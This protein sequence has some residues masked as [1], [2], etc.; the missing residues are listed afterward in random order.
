MYAPWRIAL[1]RNCR[2]RYC[3]LGQY[4]LIQIMG[5][6]GEDIRGHGLGSSWPVTERM[7]PDL[8]AVR[9]SGYGPSRR[10]SMSAHMSAV[11][12]RAELAPEPHRHSSMCVPDRERVTPKLCGGATRL[13]LPNVRSRR[14]F[15]RDMLTLRIV[16]LD[17]RSV[18]VVMTT[19]CLLQPRG[20]K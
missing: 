19:H 12:G 8:F 15:D 1:R 9:G 6:D 3:P 14:R 13:V 5:A 7:A 17:R 18:F 4:V 20:S 11:G 2:S 10:K 16:V